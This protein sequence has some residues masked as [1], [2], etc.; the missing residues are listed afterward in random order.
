MADLNTGLSAPEVLEAF[1]RAL[2]DYTNSQVDTMLAAKQTTLTFDSIPTDGST[3]PV[4]SDGIYDF[5]NS[6]VATNTAN[7][8][9]TFNSV[10]ELEAY[11]G[12]VTNN[13]YAFVI[14]TDSAG[15]TVYNRYKYNGSEWVF[16]YTLNNSSFTAAQWA[17]IQSGLTASDKTKLDGIEVGANKTVVDEN[18]SQTST[19]PVQNKIVNAA[20]ATKQDTISDLSEIR[21]GAAAGSTAVQP[22]DM[23]TALAVKQDKLTFDSTPSE[24]STNPVTSGGVWTDQQRQETEIGAVAN[25][26]AKNLLDYTFSINGDT[27]ARTSNGVTFTINTDGSISTSGTASAL[28]TSAWIQMNYVVPSDP[29][30][31]SGCPAGGANNTYRIDILDGS[32]TG[33][34]VAA[35]Y[36][37]GVVIKSSMFTNGIGLIRIGIANGQNVDGLVFK[38]MIRPA[39]I[40]DNTFVPYAKTNRELTVAEDEDRAALVAQVDGGA[41]NFLDTSV[42]T[43][44][45]YNTASSAVWNGSSYTQNGITYSVN[46]DGTISVSGTATSTSFLV[47]ANRTYLN[48]KITRGRYS[49]SGCPTGGGSSGATYR[50][51]CLNPNANISNGYTDTG[52]GYIGEFY[53]DDSKDCNISIGIGKGCVITDPV[54]FKPML[55][56]AVDY[57][58]SPAFVP[59]RPS[60]QEMWDMIQALQNG[61]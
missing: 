27:S 31:L 44:K 61:A 52:N 60:W 54:V 9:G 23:S 4:R 8:V 32:Q 33:S 51:F 11:S 29:V 48:T 55:C 7:F 53:Y 58:I 30:I 13:D 3:N 2:H 24:S 46:S 56:T 6:S 59:Y 12:T 42:S 50:I 40:T 34:V 21:S 35:D 14:S 47:L 41:K 28:I 18:L 20:L 10:A 17:T 19:N 45:K 15:N 39:S 22:A 26:G 1:D 49:I 57:A 5:V 37:N 25:A 16:E 36:G 43:L 38:P